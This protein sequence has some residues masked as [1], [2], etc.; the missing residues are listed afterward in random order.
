MRSLLALLAC[1]TILGGCATQAPPPPPPP[2]PAP[3]AQTPMVAA[4][5]PA[6][7]PQYGTFGFDAA[8]MDKSVAPGDDFFEYANGLWA[9]NTPIPPDKAR[10]GM[11]N[12]LDDLSKERTRGIIEEQSKD[13]SSKIGNAYQSFMNEA[14]IEAKGLTPFEPWLSEVRGIKSKS[15]LAKLYSDADHLGIDIPF[16]MF[17]GQ[18]RKASD[19][20]ALNVLQGGLGM[21]DRDYY[22][23]SDPKL[24]ETKAKYLEHLTNVLSL[25]GEPNAPT[26]A[27]AI[28]DFETKVAKVHWA[29]AE[30]RN[31][32]K[33]YNKMSLAQLRTFAPGFDFPGLL[34]DDGAPVDYVIVYQPSA[35]K[36]ISGLLGQTPLAVL[37]DQLLVR[38]LDSYSAYLPKKFDQEKLRILRHRSLGN[39]AAG[40]AL[41]TR[42]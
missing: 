21:P 6:P 12:V 17:V 28:L 4:P 26:R 39:A 25:A 2:P 8:G 9:K 42:G 35:F 27:K 36:G 1:G 5:A 3:I 33:T 7:K 11:F 15:G 22:L 24:V 19:V 37:R 38:S 31:A 29:R 18:D 41:E 40:A 20:Y 10:Y 16:R 30:S 23:S 34:K 14:A 13:A 32:T